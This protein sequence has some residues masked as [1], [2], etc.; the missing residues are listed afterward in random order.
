MM[1]AAFAEPRR[2]RRLRKGRRREAIK[3]MR[4]GGATSASRKS[5]L[6]GARLRSKFGPTAGQT[7][8]MQID[9]RPAEKR[10]RKFHSRLS[11]LE[12]LEAAN[13]RLSDDGDD[14]D[15]DDAAASR[16]MVTMAL[17]LGLFRE[18]SC[19]GSRSCWVG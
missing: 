4:L 19:A 7:A 6:A 11:T 1:N 10:N 3:H 17:R 2:R 16:L 5:G 13:S 18:P 12:T 15:D 9:R 14:D 8:P